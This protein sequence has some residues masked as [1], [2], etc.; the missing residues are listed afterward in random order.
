M[1]V[2]GQSIRESIE[3]VLPDYIEG[4]IGIVKFRVI[5]LAAGLVVTAGLAACGEQSTSAREVSS[6]TESPE[7]SVSEISREAAGKQYL[8]M[9]APSNEA[10][11]QLGPVERFFEE[12]PTDSNFSKL[13]IKY[14]RLAELYRKFSQNLQKARWPAGVRTDI[15]KL[16]RELDA[17][18]YAVEQL[19]SARSSDAY[20][21]ISIPKDSGSAD[22]VRARLGLPGRD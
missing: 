7:A 21:E 10:L 11:K 12:N 1:R 18:A 13:Q 20:W 2:I 16:A 9:V 6:A 8:K 15:E 3:D 17:V 14:D 4:E 19:A 22:L 5:I